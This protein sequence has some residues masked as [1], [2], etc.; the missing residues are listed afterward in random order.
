MVW[1]IRWKICI[2][3]LTNKIKYTRIRKVSWRKAI[4]IF[5]MDSTYEKWIKAKEYLKIVV[6]WLKLK[7]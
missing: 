3:K 4:K 1:K 6:K 7:K 5:I 2:K